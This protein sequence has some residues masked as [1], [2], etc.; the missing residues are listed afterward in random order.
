[1]AYPNSTVS[2]EKILL[3][4]I[5]DEDSQSMLKWLCEQ[6]MEVKVNSKLCAEKSDRNK[7]GQGYPSGYRVRRFD[8]R[9]GILPESAPNS[10]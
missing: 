10:V 6:L 2:F 9:M 4:F 5:S 7:E 8:T 3:K 1:M